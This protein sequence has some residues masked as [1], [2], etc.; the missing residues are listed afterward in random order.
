VI[1]PD[2]EKSQIGYARLAGFMF[3]FVIVADLLGMFIT[4]HFIVPGNFA[5]TAHKILASELLYR[6]GLSSGLVGSLCTV[7][8]AM[9]LYVA[10]KPIDNHLALLALAFRLAEA[11]IGGV[12]NIFGFTIL[13]LY[14]GAEYSKAFDTNQL[15]VLV[16]LPSGGFNITAIFFG[17]GSIFYFYLFLQSNYIP[18]I[19]SAL[20]LVASVLVPIICFGSLISPDHAKILQFGWLPMAVA[21]LSVGFLLLFK[22]VNL[23]AKDVRGRK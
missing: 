6:I 18:K 7:F 2:A 19:L 23:Q 5:E 22:G 12:L 1:S 9:G 4:S 11:T 8:L 13:K 14:A 3:L 20:G 15:S 16:N 10:V 17:L 21:E